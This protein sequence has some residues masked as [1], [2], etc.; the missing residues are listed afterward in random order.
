ELYCSLFLFLLS[1]VLLFISF[2]FLFLY[3]VFIAFTLSG[4]FLTHTLFCSSIIFL[5]SLYLF[6]LPSFLQLLH[7]GNKPSLLLL[8]L[9]YSVIG[10]SC[11]HF[12]HVLLFNSITSTYIISYFVI[13]LNTLY[14]LLLFFFTINLSLL[15]FI[16]LISL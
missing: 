6:L 3:F 13:L 12:E 15:I 10:F 9:L 2:L 5:F 14:Y 11:L 7:C 4:L 8:S 1:F 16:I